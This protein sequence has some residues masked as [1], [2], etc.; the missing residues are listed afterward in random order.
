VTATKAEVTKG[1]AELKK[2]FQPE[3]ISKLPKGITDKTNKTHCD[4]CG[5]YHGPASIHL[6]YVGHAAVTDRL[7]SVDPLWTWEP[8][9]HEPD[10]TPSLVVNQAGAPIGMWIKLTILGVTRIG[11]GSCEPNKSDP[12]KEL[13]GDALRNAAMRFG[14]ALDLWSKSDLESTLT[15]TETPEAS[16][17]SPAGSGSGTTRSAGKVSPDQPQPASASQNVGG[18]PTTAQS[19]PTDRSEPPSLIMQINS[20]MK[21][22]SNPEAPFTKGEVFNITKELAIEAGHKCTSAKD[23]AALPEEVLSRVVEKLSA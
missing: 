1:L 8:Y 19:A 7:L 3:A 21:T 5:G 18:G 10:G 4:V 6:D 15:K 16:A 12:V 22:P 14:V 20:F 17:N 9:G 13:I 2:P 11:Y 23:V